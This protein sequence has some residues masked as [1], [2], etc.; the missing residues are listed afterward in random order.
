MEKKGNCR[1]KIIIK[2]KNFKFLLVQESE[3][4][5]RALDRQ[6]KHLKEENIDL[7]NSIDRMREIQKRTNEA[8]RDVGTQVYQEE[9][10]LFNK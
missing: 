8:K 1:F 5:V 10:S 7:Q 9:V 4:R 3:L 2:Y 6:V